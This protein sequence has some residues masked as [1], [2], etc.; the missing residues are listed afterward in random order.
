MQPGLNWG[1]PSDHCSS[2]K[3]SRGASPE[4]CGFGLCHLPDGA[5][6]VRRPV[7]S[8]GLPSPGCRGISVLSLVIGVALE[9]APRLQGAFALSD[10]VRLRQL[11]LDVFVVSSSW[12]ELMI[13]IVTPGAGGRGTNSNLRLM[14]LIRIGRLF[15][16]VR[17]MKVVRLFRSLRTLVQ[18]LVGTLKSLAWAMVL[19]S[20]IMYIF[21]ILFTDA[22]L[23]YIIELKDQ[24]EPLTL[25]EENHLA[26]V[27]RYFGSLYRSFIT[28]PLG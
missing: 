22:A 12:I 11:R 13:D 27:S 4:S 24:V 9:L 20:L 14:R 17:I 26:D 2:K 15:R 1:S 21:A 16:V 18:S 5:P 10:C 3:T 19:L 7:H 25:E 8:G 23:D 6:D 28:M